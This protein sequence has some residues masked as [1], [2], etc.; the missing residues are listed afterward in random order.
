[1]TELS[2]IVAAKVRMS[3][4]A[5]AREGRRSRLKV[6]VVSF[7][8]L[9]LLGGAFALAHGAL[10]WLDGLGADVLGMP[11]LSLTEVLL[12]HLL[13]ALALTLLV[14][15]AFSN[16]L[17]SF[18]TLYRSQE[19]SFLLVTP[20]PVRTLFLAR[21]A[22]CVSLSSWASAFLG[23]PLLLAW[24]IER[25]LPWPFYPVAALAFVP[26][27]TIPAA[28]GAIVA[29][30][31]VRVLARVRRGAGALAVV[32]L[33]AL[34][35]PVLRAASTAPDFTR[36]LTL[37]AIVGV[38]ERADIAWLPSSWLVR[39][40]LGA[41]R[42]DAGEAVFNLLLLAANAAFLTWLATETAARVLLPGWSELAG[43]GRRRRRAG[44]GAAVRL[45]RAFQRRT[46]PLGALAIKD[47]RTFLRDPAQ[48][49]QLLIF[50][51]ILAAYVAS[52]RARAP[53]S[54]APEFWQGLI[55]LL[56]LTAC[57]LILATLTTRF[58]FP[59][60]SLEGRRFWLLALSPVPLGRLLWQKLLLA[61]AT[62]SVFT[63][64]L[65]A[66]SSWRLSLPPAAFALSV[67]TVAAATVALCGLAVGLGAV[68]PA[69]D[70]DNPA[71]IVSGLGGTLTFILSMAYVVVAAGTETVVLEWGRAGRW[72]GEG[73]APRWLLPAGVAVITT[74]S[75]LTA[76]LP[77]W[78][79]RRSLERTEL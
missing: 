66:L 14:M 15:L 52:M 18:A 28:L 61:V 74:A 47:A 53:A 11:Q 40:L 49:S 21:F 27:A 77:M 62:T 5:I 4:R 34:A 26:F 69:F 70:E 22:E 12:P 23:L 8:S 54:Y 51:G 72:L 33:I 43:L 9:L 65:V 76:A 73:P 68:Y 63:V 48:W 24:G 35:L 17:V 50:F 1:M 6:A 64:G 25:H 19:M 41:A 60:V 71:R 30:A 36:A 56:N 59:L 16:V 20:L 58:V 7:A 79:G 2:A 42:G 75:A 29:M 39:T 46:G 3:G 44:S 55:T 10:R 38:L 31:G 67:Y 57:L 45:A 13:A 78:L 37:P 32:V